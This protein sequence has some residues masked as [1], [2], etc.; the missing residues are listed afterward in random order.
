MW[1]PAGAEPAVYVELAGQGSGPR[2]TEVLS[3]IES[4]YQALVQD[5]TAECWR[6]AETLP[7][8]PFPETLSVPT[9]LRPEANT[10]VISSGSTTESV[11][12]K[13]CLTD[14]DRLLRLALGRTKA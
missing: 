11:T 5:L 3:R 4:P 2:F 6:I 7:A 10:L 8:D 9:S 12:R 13:T 14:I 1:R